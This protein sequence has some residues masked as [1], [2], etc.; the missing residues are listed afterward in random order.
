MEIEL[1]CLKWKKREKECEGN[2]LKVVVD[3]SIH[4]IH[5][6]NAEQVVLLKSYKSTEEMDIAWL[7]LTLES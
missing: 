7:W 3:M 4:V 2:E 6:F 1:N 5:S